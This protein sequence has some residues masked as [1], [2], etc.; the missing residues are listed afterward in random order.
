VITEICLHLIY[1]TEL[2]NFLIA[3]IGLVKDETLQMAIILMTH[4]AANVILGHI[5][6]RALNVCQRSTTNRRHT[7]RVAQKKVSH[8]R[9]S[10]LNRI[11]NRQPG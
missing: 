11:K 7:Y 2:K 9:E 5:K 3:A 6:D 1:H 8:Y 4:E 10:S